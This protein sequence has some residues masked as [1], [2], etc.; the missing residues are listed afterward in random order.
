MSGRKEKGP[1]GLDLSLI[2]TRNALERIAGPVYFGR[3][4]GY[5]ESRRVKGLVE[6]DGRIT[7]SVRGTEKYDVSLWAERGRLAYSCTCPLGEDGEFCKHCVAV[8]L[9]WLGQ[10]KDGGENEDDTVSL[11]DLRNYL[12]GREKRVL[13]EIILEEARKNDRLRYRLLAKAA[14]ASSKRLNLGIFRAAV[15]RVL[16]PEGH[17]DYRSMRDYAEGIGSAV[18]SIEDLLKEGYASE[19]IELCEYALAGIEGVME[20]V[21]DSS[22]FMREILDR[23]DEIH[24]AACRKAS[25]R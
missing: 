18:D 23:L 1:E 5:F 25:G 3:G 16:E 20:Y 4:E 7:A 24:L 13:A 6:L 9:E 15:D 2:L 21:D 19:A 12:L 17:V 10:G 22:G 8:G 14:R 11:D